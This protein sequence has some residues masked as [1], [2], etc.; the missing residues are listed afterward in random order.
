MISKALIV[1]VAAATSQLAQGQGDLDDHGAEDPNSSR[2]AQIEV[3]I[4]PETLISV[5]RS[6]GTP[7]VATCGSA[8]EFRVKIVNQGFLTAPLVAGIVEPVSQGIR[9]DFPSEPLKGT[10]EEQRILRIVLTQA[11]PVDVTIAFRADH[12]LANLGGRDRIHFVL[13][14]VQPVAG[15]REVGGLLNNNDRRP[16][17]LSSQT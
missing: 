13:H 2:S 17:R 11:G 4:N 6:G 14:C 1:V 3:V 9:L 12:G 10:R 16:W 8:T 15:Y 7:P 5:Y